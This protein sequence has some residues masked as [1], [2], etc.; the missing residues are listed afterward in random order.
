MPL[1]QLKES[2][3]NDSPKELARLADEVLRLSG[4]VEGPLN[5]GKNR[6]P[7]IA[8]PEWKVWAEESPRPI[9]GTE[10]FQKADPLEKLVLSPNATSFANV[11]QYAFLQFVGDSTQLEQKSRDVELLKD[12]NLKKILWVFEEGMLFDFVSTVKKYAEYCETH[13]S[14]L[15]EARNKGWERE[16]K[17]ILT[18][19]KAVLPKIAIALQI[20][21]VEQT[22]GLAQKQNDPN[23][24]AKMKQN[25][26]DLRKEL[27]KITG[28]ETV[29]L[30]VDGKEEDI[31]ISQDISPEQLEKALW[32]WDRQLRD[33]L[34]T[35]VP[36][37]VKAD[38]FG[39][40]MEKLFQEIAKYTNT[41]QF[42]FGKENPQMRQ[43]RIAHAMYGTMVMKHLHEVTDQIFPTEK[44]GKRVPVSVERIDE[45]SRTLEK[46]D[47]AWQE[48]APAIVGFQLDTTSML[49]LMG[50]MGPYVRQA[51]EDLT[52][53]EK[54][55]YRK[56]MLPKEI[57]GELEKK[58]PEL[59]IAHLIQYTS[60]L[61]KD[62]TA[63]VGQAQAL[64]TLVTG[65][66]ESILNTIIQG[67]NDVKITAI[68]VTW[69]LP[70]KALD[71][72]N[73][74]RLKPE[75]VRRVQQIAALYS[76]L[77]AMKER[78][79]RGR[80]KIR[81][82]KKALQEAAKLSQETLQKMEK[83]LASEGQR[84]V[85]QAD[86]QDVRLMNQ[87]VMAATNYLVDMNADLTTMM[88]FNALGSSG[89]ANK[90]DLSVW[91]AIEIAPFYDW[92]LMGGWGGRAVTE[93]PGAL[94]RGTA[95][96]V[97][98]VGGKIPGS[99]L[100][101][102]LIGKIPGATKFGNALNSVTYGPGYIGRAYQY[103]SPSHFV[104]RV[105]N[106]RR[107]LANSA[108]S[109][110]AR[111][112]HELSLDKAGRIGLSE[113]AM[114]L[115]S[116]LK[117]DPSK[118]TAEAKSAIGDA[119]WNAHDI[120]MTGPKWTY[121]ELRAKID[122]LKGAGLSKD[123]A[124][125]LVKN[126]FCGDFTVEEI[127]AMLQKNVGPQ[128]AEEFLVSAQ[129]LLM[130][131]E[132]ANIMA[133]LSIGAAAIGEGIALRSSLNDLADQMNRITKV[134]EQMHQTLIGLGF[135]YDAKT[136]T[137][138]NEEAGVKVSLQQL[139]KPLDVTTQPD[140]LR[141]IGHGAN[142]TA[143]LGG[144]AALYLGAEIALGPAGI[145]IAA[146][147]VTVEVVAS[148]IR[149]RQH[150]QLIA[151]WPAWLLAAMG[152]AK[153]LG[154]T[155]YDMITNASSWTLIP[156][157]ERTMKDVR[158]KNYFMLF[159]SELAERARPLYDRIFRSKNDPR[160]IEDFFRGDFRTVTLP[161]LFLCL[162]RAAQ[163]M[164]VPPQQLD[165]LR[166]GRIDTGLG[167]LPR[168]VC[169]T[170]VRQAC[171]EA[172]VFT[173][174]DFEQM[175]LNRLL[176]A[177]KDYE[178]QPESE[179]YKRL[180]RAVE[181]QS[182]KKIFGKTMGEL[183]GQKS[184]LDDP[185]VP[186]TLAR[187]ILRDL[188]RQLENG[189]TMTLTGLSSKYPGLPDTLDFGASDTLASLCISDPALR[190]NLKKIG[191]KTV[192]EQ[193]AMPLFGTAFAP[194]EPE[195]IVHR[196]TV[197]VLLRT[198]TGK[199]DGKLPENASEYATH[200]VLT[201][202]AVAL[203][204]KEPQKL[205]EF[206]MLSS[207]SPFHYFRGEGDPLPFEGAAQKQAFQGEKLVAIF[208]QQRVLTDGN[209]LALFTCVYGDSGN[210]RDIIVSQEA[211]EKIQYVSG[212]HRFENK[213]LS[214]LPDLTESSAKM[215][216]EMKERREPV[217]GEPE[218]F[219]G[220]PDIQM[221]SSLGHTGQYLL[222][223]IQSTEASERERTEIRAMID[224]LRGD[225]PPL[226]TPSRYSNQELLFFP[227]EL[228]TS[229]KELGVKSL[230]I[231]NR[232]TEYMTMKN[233]FLT[234]LRQR[235]SS[236]GQSTASS[237]EIEQIRS[238]YEEIQRVRS[239]YEVSEKQYR[240]E[241]ESLRESILGMKNVTSTALR[242]LSARE[243][244]QNRLEAQLPKTGP[245]ALSL[246][247]T[248]SAQE[249]TAVRD[250]L[251][252]TE[253]PYV[254]VSGNLDKQS[255]IPVLQSI[256]A[257]PSLP[258][259]N[260][261]AVYIGKDSDPKTGD[262]LLLELLYSEDVRA[263]PPILQRLSLGCQHIDGQWEI[264]LPIANASRYPVDRTERKAD[265]VFNP[266]LPNYLVSL[267]DAA[268]AKLSKQ[269]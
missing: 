210:P 243:Q 260:L 25:S 231:E 229:H 191:P 187:C 205:E 17:S 182:Q 212:H 57:V 202:A 268:R 160:S 58:Q 251:F 51:V 146:V 70:G 36:Y 214:L 39:K 242:S 22:A 163:K 31:S 192:E 116:S 164:G 237:S 256:L 92:L 227:D 261:L 209:T 219:I 149:N 54:E 48:Y 106:E 159:S 5:S 249:D 178:D 147:G 248:K 127:A 155:E 64:D 150:R 265:A 4:Y 185:S 130:S 63:K 148:A 52:P 50:Q 14:T 250:T 43:T 45:L 233:R 141:S 133:K 156:E 28:K 240:S 166:Q 162:A 90:H 53:D 158:D 246:L 71:L 235:D 200:D 230:Q 175:R 83:K 91:T 65:M 183:V 84:Q 20:N 259:K 109:A 222:D 34:G 62:L 197:N 252:P 232:R 88:I 263:N 257:M 33:T 255:D 203:F 49:Y 253:K 101:A 216:E 224:A 201:R 79:V 24:A 105:V 154:R 69:W 194:N 172:A 176:Y 139:Q 142:L 9:N 169:E 104:G 189:G 1:D 99:K 128:A 173:L 103:T 13:Q 144:G 37:E 180:S 208:Q 12:V 140:L 241:I 61:Q 223:Q 32:E 55:F 199:E 72:V 136:E 112:L 97:G 145:A 239:T 41:E 161:Y 181:L 18:N 267:V 59:N 120:E 193:H 196:E 56:H 47:G 152:G 68:D 186:P 167:I 221:L 247:P 195:R 226:P 44:D 157:N 100:A 66:E 244:F 35:H 80:E 215:K 10:L 137:Y 168:A 16:V 211:Q 108:N 94:L 206:R 30:K 121:K 89:Y 86:L 26:G 198:A 98:A 179:E 113:R 236:R 151:Q 40:R 78:V 107:Q 135:I 85:T 110:A 220:I 119:I 124:F 170:L 138:M 75:D 184:R 188:Q 153:V 171:L 234:E 134:K 67:L 74:S 204:Q 262:R 174:Q 123:Q 228:R 19:L 46:M 118:L 115:E 165:E 102:K 21:Y 117:F 207:A 132:T 73:L 96:L 93:T 177:R 2:A 122:I 114:A 27:L 76:R 38:Y 11:V 7:L 129:K 266:T 269:P 81:N 6:L 225:N 29:K 254:A 23:R 15:G 60:L 3:E 238:Q 87:R 111:S 126:G 42:I 8:T 258:R 190:Y 95:R 82:T 131:A 77:T 217:R 245:G 264:G 143:I 125:F 218:H 213:A